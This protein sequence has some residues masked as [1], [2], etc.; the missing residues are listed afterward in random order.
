MKILYFGSV[1]S[2]YQ[3][4]FWKEC[5]KFFEIE[6]IYL[7]GKESGHEWQ[8]P[9]EEFI[10]PLDY[11]QSKLKSFF[12]L[13]S[14]LKSNSPDVIVIGG[15]KMPFTLFLIFW[16][17]FKKTK[18]YLWLERPFL[19]GTTRTL[20]RNIYF[21]F[22]SFFID[23]IFA[24]GEDA[25]EIYKPYFKDVF[26]L[27]YS[28]QLGRFKKKE[29]SEGDLKF[30]FLGQYINRKGVLE[31]VNSFKDLPK[32]NTSLTLAGGGVLSEQI[33]TLISSEQNIKNVG[34]LDYSDIP[35]FLAEYDVFILPSKHDGWGVVIAEAMAAGLFILGTKYTSACNEYILEK[36]N[37]LF[38]ETDKE[39]IKRGI[40][41][42]IEHSD[43]VKSGGISNQ[44]LIKESL[45]NSEI[46]S[47]SLREFFKNNI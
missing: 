1:S 30:V 6:N 11:D 37:G 46:S 47:Q 32:N 26:N 31:L 18:I 14:N 9:V 21:K 2:P 5:S 27:P 40:L 38:V 4:S 33:N 39:N 36:K 3:N 7:S 24:I 35:S 29:P 28:F 45:S 23:G 13:T 43:L 42:C 19:R 22:L 8:I 44:V 41:W 34:Y 25:C 10:Y 12:K 16:Y 15:Y 17:L 20:L